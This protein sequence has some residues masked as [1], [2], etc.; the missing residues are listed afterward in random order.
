MTL[1][2]YLVKMASVEREFW[3]ALWRKNLSNVINH[4]DYMQPSDFRGCLSL[5][6]RAREWQQDAVVV[7]NAPVGIEWVDTGGW[8]GWGK[9]GKKGAECLETRDG[10][11][12]EPLEIQPSSLQPPA[13]CASSL[14][15]LPTNHPTLP[16]YIL[17]CSVGHTIWGSAAAFTI[18]EHELQLIP[19]SLGFSFQSPFHWGFILLGCFTIC[20]CNTA[21][22]LLCLPV[23]AEAWCAP[24]CWQWN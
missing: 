21:L 12:C 1:W 24:C 2:W 22:G 5:T 10:T 13:F 18:V 8:F 3:T 14:H 20:C 17:V 4:E 16:S 15:S 9:G 6:A 19:L 11:L 7:L 23:R